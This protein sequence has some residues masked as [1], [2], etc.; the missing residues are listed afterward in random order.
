MNTTQF[1]R[2]IVNI[3]E[4]HIILVEDSYLEKCNRIKTE[5][6]TILIDFLGKSDYLSITLDKVKSL[7]SNEYVSHVHTLRTDGKWIWS[8]DLNHY[9]KNH[10]FQWP[11]SFNEHVLKNGMSTISEERFKLMEKSFNIRQLLVA[12]INKFLK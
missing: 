9:T 1:K 4:N 8:S 12:N 5:N 2:F 3:D 7:F 10:Y 6:S 11:K